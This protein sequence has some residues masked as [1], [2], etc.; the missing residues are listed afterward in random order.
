MQ[1]P[2]VTEQT[3]L[4][5][6]TMLRRIWQGFLANRALV[7]LALGC[8]ALEAFCTKVPLLLI[9]PLMR[10]L[11]H[12]EGVTR[13]TLTGGS[14][15]VAW[16]LDFSTSV[17]GWLGLSVDSLALELVFGCAFA[18]ML[19]ALPGALAM[20]GVL[21]F[22][23]Y[24]ATKL[25]VDLR[26]EVAAHLLRLPL[27]YFGMQRM[28]ELISSLTTNTTALTRSF[29]LAVDNAIVDPLMIVMNILL[30]LVVM[31]E[32]T[33]VVVVMLPLFALPM[34]KLGRK[35]Q[36]TSSR[37]LAAMGE[38]TE[39]MNQ[40]LSGIKTVKA[41]QL[42]RQRLNEF[43]QNNNRY[44]RR[45]KSMLRTKALSQAGVYAAYQLAFAALLLGFG[46]FVLSEYRTFAEIAVAIPLLA[47]NYQH[48]KHLTRA[49]NVLMEST[50][51]L[52]SIEEVLREQPDA[53]AT[54]VAQQLARPRGAITFERV[55]FRYEREPVLR[56][57]SFRIDPGQTVA[58]VGPSGAGKSTAV[59]LMLRFHDPSEGRVLVDGQDL[60]EV[61]LASYRRH[62]AVV[63]QQPFLFNTSLYENILCG[64]PDATR[65][66]VEVAAQQAQIH[67]FIQSLPQGYESP[68]GERGCNLSG[69]QM[70]RIT[71]ARAILRDPAILFLD[72]ATS[73]LDS[74]SEDAVQRALQN[75]MH[76]R[77]SVVIAH[78]LAT[79]RGAD[80]ILVLENGRL[81]EQGR[82]EELLARAGVYQRL[83]ELQDLR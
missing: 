64:R 80:Q 8:G 36:R 32:A 56:E 16:M 46:W 21:V 62:V 58:L 73:A 9:E 44:L 37:S 67:E 69:G 17:T 31:P 5:V 75:L 81:V 78:R 71:I 70:Q 14:E 7:W 24:F 76:G 30:L 55:S 65:E 49:Y 38:S 28:G 83:T 79:V 23:R 66:Q 11:Q 45:T 3:S 26:N 47:T 13:E 41:F 72:E 59:D 20:Y 74:E 33:L 50:G 53:G 52:E 10:A 6:R 22:S 25:V 27:R 63:T 35:V 40:I 82:H 4:P 1:A 42:E 61:E 68:A 60:R 77:T 29:S 48:V 15:R 19:F 43:E 57:V 12:G 39:S 51:A 34:I 18:A 54:G 2:A